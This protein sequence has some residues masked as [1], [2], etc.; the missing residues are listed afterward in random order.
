MKKVKTF[1][2]VD[3]GIHHEQYF[4]GFGCSFADSSNEAWGIGDSVAEAL[5]DCL[6]MIAQSGDVDVEDLA[7][8]ILKREGKPSTDSISLIRIEDFY[9]YIGIRWTL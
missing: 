7:A 6:E 3:L 9:Q 4:Q 1:E 2:V 8:R 5:D